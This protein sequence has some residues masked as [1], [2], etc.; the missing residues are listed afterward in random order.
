MRFLSL[1]EDSEAYTLIVFGGFSGGSA[2]NC[3]H[4]IKDGSNV[5]LVDNSIDQPGTATY[6]R[7]N[8]ILTD[9]IT[10]ISGVKT[11]PKH[12]AL[13]DGTTV[14]VE[15]ESLTDGLLLMVEEITEEDGDLY[16]WLTD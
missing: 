11:V 16:F 7:E 13:P 14:S 4:T 1:P 8:V 15:G 10:L 5:I 12:I 3:K 6:Y 9:S 2:V